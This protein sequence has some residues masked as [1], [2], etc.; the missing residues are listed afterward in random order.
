MAKFCTQCG[1]PLEKGH[2]CTCQEKNINDKTKY[3][4]Y[5]ELFLNLTKGIFLEPVDTIKKQSKKEHFLFSI[6]MIFVNAI[7]SGLL[8]YFIM[9]EGYGAAKYNQLFLTVSFELP[10]LQIFL[11][12]TLFII[13]GIVTSIISIYFLAHFLLKS[14]V[15][16]KEVIS[17]VGTCSIVTTITNVV[18][19]ITSFISIKLTL[20]TIFVSSLLY[21]THIYQGISEITKIDKNKRAY[22]FASTIVII[23][24]VVFYLLPTI[25][26]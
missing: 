7:L 1:K 23:L 10:F 4:K 15:D 25:L 24:F 13:V 11:K 19:I 16:I 12:S 17:M 6:L 9:K 22:L 2:T 5:G 20:F 21:W 8:C 14:K 26:F 3:Q 18:A